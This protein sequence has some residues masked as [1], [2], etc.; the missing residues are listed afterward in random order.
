MHC[1]FSVVEAGPSGCTRQ[2]LW[3]STAREGKEEQSIF[4][5]VPPALAGGRIGNFNLVSGSWA[6][7]GPDGYLG[8][9]KPE[10][11]VPE[12][13]TLLLVGTGALGAIG[14]IRRRQLR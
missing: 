7:Y 8:A 4:V 3:P 2:G 11:P 5:T 13:A 14:I 12:P 1:C 9:L 10:A 6:L